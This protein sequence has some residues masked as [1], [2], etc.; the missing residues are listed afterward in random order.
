V[1]AHTRRLETNPV[2]NLLN[3]SSAEL[4]VQT[5]VAEKMHI[6]LQRTLM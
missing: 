3:A 5:E 2:Q 1:R 6:A 4:I